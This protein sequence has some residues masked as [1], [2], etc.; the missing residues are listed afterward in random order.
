MFIVILGVH[1]TGPFFSFALACE[2]RLAPFLCDLP[3][4][5]DAARYVLGQTRIDGGTFKS[6]HRPRRSTV[7]GGSKRNPE[8]CERGRQYID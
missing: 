4:E 7:T 5:F 6:M 2:A 8:S 1:S 3:I